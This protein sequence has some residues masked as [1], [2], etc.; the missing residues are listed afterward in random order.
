MPVEY[1]QPASGL[2]IVGPVVKGVE[3]RIQGSAAD[4]EKLSGQSLS[5]APDLSGL[6]VGVQTLPVLKERIPLPAGVSMIGVKPESLT[7][8]VEKEIVKE[9]P[10]EIVLTGKPALGYGITGFVS[11]PLSAVLRGPESHLGQRIKIPT[12]PIDITGLSETFRKETTLD[13]PEG[14]NVVSG[15]KIVTAEIFIEEKIETREFQDLVVEGKDASH[16]FS[17]TPAVVS[18]QVKGPINVLEKLQAEKGIGVY[19]D[20]KGLAPGVYVRRATITLPVNT[21][22]VGVRPEIFT[23]KLR[24]P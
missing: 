7:L 1:A 22:L 8:R 2:T 19:V 3:V 6:S 23:V 10:V 12:K 16:A 24:R 17:V 20:L 13:L 11:R 18:I 5:Y 4:V 9:V 21:T 15:S 14:L